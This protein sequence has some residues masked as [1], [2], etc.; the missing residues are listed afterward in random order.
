MSAANNT[1][2]SNKRKKRP[3]VTVREMEIDDLPAV[4]HLGE[5]LFTAKVVPNL[6]RTWDEFELTSFFQGDSELCLVAEI[7][8][9]VVGF[10]LG[11]TIHKNR[12]AWKYGY[13]VWLGINPEFQGRGIGEKLFLQI[14]ERMHEDKVNIMLVD[15]Q[16]DNLP[17]LRF[18]R[19]MGFG[20][21]EEHIYLTLNLAP[22]RKE[23]RPS[24]ENGSK[25]EEGPKE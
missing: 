23:R 9:Q 10:V 22:R 17:A 6:Y 3:H 14:K 18:F 8:D 7:E 12:S 11:T 1:E 25:V 21:P 4:F 24:A 2:W 16:A 15:T 13:L 19:K 20:R 5:K